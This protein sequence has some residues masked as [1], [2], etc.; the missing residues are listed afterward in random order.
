MIKEMLPAVVLLLCLLTVPPQTS[1]QKNARNKKQPAQPAVSELSEAQL[2]A[3]A[4]SLVISLATND[5]EEEARHPNRT[6]GLTRSLLLI[7][8]NR[9]NPV[10]T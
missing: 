5:I 8:L 3:F 4:I 9:A 7:L 1:G 6:T 10:T 2:P